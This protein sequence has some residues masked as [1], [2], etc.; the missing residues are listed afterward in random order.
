MADALQSLIGHK[1]FTVLR[2]NAA[3]LRSRRLFSTLAAYP[4]GALK[5]H[6][7]GAWHDRVIG[8]GEPFVA[9]TLEAVR[10]SFPDHAGIEAAGCGSIIA[11]P[12][13]WDGRMLATVN[14]WHVSGHYDDGA[15]RRAWPLTV[16]LV[17]ACLTLPSP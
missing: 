17:P 11:L 13:R 12:V 14:V 7:R 8:A 10:A 5:D 15:A 9:P 16:L 1:V 2:L 3:G 6:R 4:P